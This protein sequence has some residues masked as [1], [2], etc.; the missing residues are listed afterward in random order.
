MAFTWTLAA[1]RFPRLNRRLIS[2]SRPPRPPDVILLPDDWTGWK[3]E[4]SCEFDP[5][6][7]DYDIV[8]TFMVTRRCLRIGESVNSSL[9]N[10]YL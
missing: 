5:F 9:K 10:M 3:S 8:F 1:L 4:R 2:S 6:D 7:A